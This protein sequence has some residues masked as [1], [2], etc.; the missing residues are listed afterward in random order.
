M[1]EVAILHYAGPPVVGGVEW[2][3]EM[4]ARLLTE[5][6]FRV[7]VVA[8]R[9]GDFHPRVRSISIPELDSRHRE[10]LEVGEE[11]AKGKVSGRFRRLQAVI[12]EKLQS[13]LEGVEVCIA[14]NVTTLHKNLPLTAALHGMTISGNGMRLVSWA[15]DFAWLD[16]LY[17]PNLHDGYPW[18]LLREPW[19]GVE[20]VVVS[21]DRRKILA[22]LFRWPEERIHVVPPGITPESLLGISE[23]GNRISRDLGLWEA[24]PCL[25]LPARITRRK[26]IELGIRVM[27]EI[28]RRRPGAK[29]VVTGP[30]G[31]HNPS[32][33]EYLRQLMT[34]R[35]E[36]R[37]KENV[38]FMYE[39]GEEGKPFVPDEELMAELYRVCDALFFPSKR[40]GFGIPILE[41]GISRMHVFCSDIPPFRE[42]GDGFVHTFGLDDSPEMIAGE[43]ISRLEDDEP[44]RMRKRVLAGYTWDKIIDGK[45]I[46]LLDG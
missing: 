33:I 3:I 7:R 25:L 44:Y 11:L 22:K 34:L 4:H 17:T 15:H 18:D 31:P 21:E 13:A 29:L 45:V 24:D 10:V 19:H 36:L 35:E 1:K 2:T 5:R 12:T 26:N 20:Y 37:V 46:P 30:P 16:P 38:L 40:E 32:N 27:G 42:S 14:H 8:G 41:A 43:I 39:L 9:V 23:E 6:G 28:A